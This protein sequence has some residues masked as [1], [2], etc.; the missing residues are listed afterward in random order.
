MENTMTALELLN[1][2]LAQQEAGI[3]LSQIEIEGKHLIFDGNVYEEH[4]IYVDN[5]YIR[6]DSFSTTVLVLK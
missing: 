2:L 4:T 6:E 1:F 5:I 3:D